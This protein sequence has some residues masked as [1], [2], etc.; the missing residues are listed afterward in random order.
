[1]QA[2]PS[3]FHFRSHFYVHL[4][5]GPLTRNHPIDDSV[6]RLHGLG[7][8]P[9]CYPSYKTLTPLLMGLT[10]IEHTRFIW[11]HNPA[12]GFPALGLPVGFAPRLMGPIGWER[13]RS[14]T[15]T[16]PG[17]AETNTKTAKFIGL[18]LSVNP[19]P[20]VLQIMDGFITPSLPPCVVGG[21]PT[22][23]RLRS[24]GVTPHPHYYT[25]ISHRLVFPSTSQCLWL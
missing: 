2:R 3:R 24:A 15:P 5:Y 6:D 23:G 10:P 8:P 25:P 7:Y 14:S 9:P 17:P 19:P 1:M 21:I 12:C 22:V 13:F 18:R 11:T 16:P 20:Q 4:H